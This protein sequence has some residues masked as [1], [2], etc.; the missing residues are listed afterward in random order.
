MTGLVTVNLTPFEVAEPTLTRTLPVAAPDGTLTVKTVELA[1]NAGTTSVP[2]STLL[3]LTK[4]SEAVGENP[5]PEIVTIVPTGPLF[6]RRLDIFTFVTVA[7]NTVKCV[8]SADAVR[9]DGSTAAT[10]RRRGVREGR[11][12]TKS[13]MR[14]VPPRSIGPKLTRRRGGY[15]A[16]LSAIDTG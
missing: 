11:S 13:D 9:P 15:L 14:A 4:S 7:A 10:K 1:V 6:G 12:R 2:P 16:V 3:N 8:T 5:D